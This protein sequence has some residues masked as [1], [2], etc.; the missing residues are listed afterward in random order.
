MNK[1]YNPKLYKPP[2]KQELS[3]ADRITLN[4]GGTLAPTFLGMSFVQEHQDLVEEVFDSSAKE[5]SG[6]VI[7]MM[8]MLKKDVQ[9]EVDEM[10][11][12]ERDAQAEYEELLTAAKEKRHAD[13]SAI[14]EKEAA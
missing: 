5:E 11:I 7:A 14:Q 9:K 4:I 10:K 13:A 1:F 6:G 3:E 12:D 2:P 8:E